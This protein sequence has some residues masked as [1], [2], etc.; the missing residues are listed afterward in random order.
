MRRIAAKA[1]GEIERR[2]GFTIVELIMVV[3]IIGILA[4]MATTNYRARLPKIRAGDAAR[5]IWSDFHRARSNASK[6]KV[7]TVVI[8][9][10]ANNTYSIVQDTDEDLGPG[11]P[12]SSDK[13]I[14]KNKT[15]PKGIEFA[16]G[17][18]MPLGHGIPLGQN[19]GSVGDGVALKDNRIF[20][21]RSGHATDSNADEAAALPNEKLRSVYIMHERPNINWKDTLYAV[22]VEPISGLPKMYKYDASSGKWKE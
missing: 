15:L 14:E 11:T 6:S 16:S 9:N 1:C 21:Q 20:F 22:Y 10:T 7:D 8:F 3:A 17:T 13:F 5:Q 2:R 12:N 4:A 18:G 19:R